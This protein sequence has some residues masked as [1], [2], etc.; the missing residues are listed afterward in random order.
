MVFR[1]ES[2]SIGEAKTYFSK[3]VRRVEAGEEIVVR[4]GSEPVARIVPLEKRGG[5]RGFGSMK[6]EIEI[7]PDF[8]EPL[9]EFAEYEE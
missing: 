8:D 6:G 9:E 3:L 4:R 2:F 7:G 1:S 5:V